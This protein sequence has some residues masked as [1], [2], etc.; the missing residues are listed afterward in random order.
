MR[1]ALSDQPAPG[2]RLTEACDELTS[3][4]R[5]NC[6][7]FPGRVGAARLSMTEED[8]AINFS[9]DPKSFDEDG[10]FC[11]ICEKHAEAAFGVL[12]F[13]RACR[14]PRSRSWRA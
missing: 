14:S 10:F 8:A 5:C 12:V 6:W 9:D 13:D 3:D 4:G 11:G 2:P 1:F 7:V